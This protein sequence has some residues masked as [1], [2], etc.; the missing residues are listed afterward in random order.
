M[1]APEVAEAVRRRS[2]EEG[3]PRL[4]RRGLL[5]AGAGSALA[6]S[7]PAQARAWHRPRNRDRVQDLTHLFR[8]GFPTFNPPTPSR[9]TIAD[10]ATH[11][12][13]AQSW[14]FGEHS[15]THMDVPGHFVPG[16][17][18]TP[19][20]RPEELI[21]PAAVVD[22]SR[23]AAS[24][25]DAVV[26][27]D[28]LRSYERRHGRIER[29]AIVFMDSGWWRKAGDPL[30]FKGGTAFPNYHFPGFGDE[31]VEWLLEERRI[32]GIGV[33]TISLDPGNS[34]TFP[35]HLRLLGADKYG[36]ENVAMLDRIPPRGATV[37]VG[38]I[39]WEQGSGGPCR[40]IA[41][42]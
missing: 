39:P 2:E 10:F 8:A 9:A 28:D 29:G 30:A 3:R 7:F 18:L 6:A 24:N 42:W 13:Y 36:L 26:T 27:R 31:A 38:V 25:P 33:D 5:L 41:R 19:A 16:A 34:T 12:F 40:V 17:R 23:R 20:I 37:Y 32:T 4:D 11:G 14:T 22:I 1:C 21:A 15:G 35:V